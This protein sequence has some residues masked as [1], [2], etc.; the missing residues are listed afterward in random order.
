MRPVFVG[1]LDYDTRHS[2]L[3]HLFYRYGRV[4]RI[5][6]K[7][8]FA[9]VYFEDERD[10]SDAIRALDGY[11]FGP[12]RRRLSVEW[13]RGDRAARRDGNKP[14]VNTKP[15]KT[16]FVI[17]FDPMDTRVSD[18]ERHF[19][20]FGNISSVRIRKNFAFVRF[21]TLEEA[22]KAL[23]ATHATMLLDRVISVEYAFRD[24]DERSDRYDSPRRGGGYGRRG[25]SPAYRSRPSPDYGRPASPVYGSYG[26]SRSPVRDRYR[27]S[28]AYRS[29]SPPANRRAYD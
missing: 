13:S 21:E 12:G 27:R 11:P 28:P 9:F 17:N 20:P 22:R 16:L 18:I 8:G 1:N 3:D 5:D 24:D 7:S 10:G 2:E 15:T 26:R 23:E 6:M 4:E 25:D 29:R 19:A 14:E